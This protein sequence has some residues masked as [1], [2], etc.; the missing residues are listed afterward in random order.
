MST[1]SRRYGWVSGS[2]ESA[3]NGFSTGVSGDGGK[4]V[5]RLPNRLVD[6]CGTAA[7]SR[8]GEHEQHRRTEG[9]CVR[10]RPFRVVNLLVPWDLAVAYL[11][12]RE[13]RRLAEHLPAWLDAWHEAEALSALAGMADRRADAV[14]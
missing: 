8:P 3:S 7:E 5:E 4:R 6:S 2:R 12:R 11:L 1:P 10:N 14:T 13:R 9:L